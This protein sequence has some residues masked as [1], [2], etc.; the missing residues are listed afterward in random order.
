MNHP[1]DRLFERKNGADRLIWVV[2]GLALTAIWVYLLQVARTL[3]AAPFDT[4]EIYLDAKIFGGFNAYPYHWKRPPLLPWLLAPFFHFFPPQTVKIFSQVLAVFFY[5]GL[6]F[7][8]YRI[9]RLSLER[10]KALLGTSL[11]ALNP[12]ILHHA[13]FYKEDIAASA[14]TT[15]AFW[16]YLKFRTQ[17]NVLRYVVIGSVLGLAGTTR[18]NM[19]PWLLLSIVLFE[20]LSSVRRPVPPEK[21]WTFKIDLWGMK[22]VFLILFPVLF[23]L[24]AI[25]FSWVIAMRENWP[26]S[27][28]HSLERLASYYFQFLDT[29]DSPLE[30][31]AF[32]W[33]AFT[34]PG[35]VLCAAGIA[36]SWFRKTPGA[37]WMS[38]WLLAFGA[39][40]L[41]LTHSEARYL[42]PIFPP[43]CFFI[44]VGASALFGWIREAFRKTGFSRTVA[45]ALTVACFTP[46]SLL[47]GC[48]AMAE[49][50]KFQDPFYRRPY[51]KNVSAAAA[52][53]A[54]ERRI[55]WVGPMYPIHPQQYVFHPKDEVCYLYHFYNHTVRFYTGKRVFVIAEDNKRLYERNGRLFLAEAARQIQDGDVLII[56]PNPR[57]YDAIDM[58]E[59]LLPLFVQKC[60]IIRFDLLPQRTG[61]PENL[62]SR[63]FVSAQDAT[64]ML[65]T[66]KRGSQVM[67]AGSKLPDGVYELY[68]LKSGRNE[69]SWIG[70]F[71]VKNGEL[72]P[73]AFQDGDFNAYFLLT[74]TSPITF[75]QP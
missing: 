33:K 27:I 41:F 22:L 60:R 14:L 45:A 46:C 44:T 48:A 65:Q 69:P 3:E 6:I 8:A 51:M 29:G 28:A 72:S 53:L 71:P 61:T 49:L 30:N 15:L 73:F 57:N 21:A 68:G 23:V 70:T 13:P 66:E 10:P 11:L 64:G 55:Y 20:I 32:L 62:S 56:N 2:A 75:S 18:Y 9:F 12:L 54:Q 1:I 19:P 50:H 63:R 7:A 37:L 58:P 42:F 16:L 40:Q 43:V 59:K 47:Y 52:A 4:Y 74:Y 35:I 36:V 5:T 34:G 31:L 38:L 25:S 39:Q 24:G 67:L 17:K 26:L